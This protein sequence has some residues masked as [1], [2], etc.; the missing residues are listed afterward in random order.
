MALTCNGAVEVLVTSSM[1]PMDASWPRPN[2]DVQGRVV[3]WSRVVL[4]LSLV[5]SLVDAIAAGYGCWGLGAG[6]N[7]SKKITNDM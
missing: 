2:R 6:R 4:M 3:G 1:C 7:S 5:A